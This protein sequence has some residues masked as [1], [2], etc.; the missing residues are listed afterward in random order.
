MHTHK[1]EGIG[2]ITYISCICLVYKES[3]AKT[4]RWISAHIYLAVHIGFIAL[5][6][7]NCSILLEGNLAPECYWRS[8]II[9][10]ESVNVH[11]VR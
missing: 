11:L 7:L 3:K 2:T 10:K 1:Q 9:N 8:L 5:A 4:F 6:R